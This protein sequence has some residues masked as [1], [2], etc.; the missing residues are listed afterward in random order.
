MLAFL[1]SAPLRAEDLTGRFAVGGAAG[2]GVPLGNAWVRDHADPAGLLLGGFLRYG[3]TKHLSLGLSYD[4]LGLGKDGIRLQPVLFNVYYNLKP[5]SCWNPN[6]HL[7]MGAA[8]VSRD[9]FSQHTNFSGKLG[10]GAD[11]F[12]L[13]N[14]AVGGFLD[15][16]LVVR[17]LADDYSVH[18]LLAGLTVALWFDPFR[19]HAAE[20]W[21][22]KAPAVVGVALTPTTA[23]L[24][25]N[26]SLPFSASVTGTQNAA[27]IWS[28]EPK[29]GTIT[30]SGTYQAPAVIT[31]EQTVNITATS[32]ADPSKS[33][34]SQVTLLAPA[35]SVV[36]VTLAPATAE[37]SA[38][39]SLPFS[40]SVSGTPNTA[41]TWSLQPRLGTITGSGAY[42][43]PAVIAAEQTVYVTATSQAD[44]SKSATSQLRLRAPAKVA[45]RLA[46]EF[47]IAQAVVKPQYD[48]ELQKV[49]QFIQ[50][51]PTARAEIEGHT[52]KVG[53][54]EYNLAL[55][56]RRAEA[57][58]EALI[59]RCGVPADRL[60]ARGYGSTQPIADN[61]TREGRARNRRVI[62]TFTGTKP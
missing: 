14:V 25:A 24:A 62:A 53:S 56:Q 48:Y 38:N 16:F 43:A 6:I 41:V 46:I 7:G 49:A 44:P 15:Y 1:L 30:G 11:Y 50:D 42:T 26:S 19:S 51:Y 52:D 45:M 40:A 32:Q 20:P 4:D 31:A 54:P 18:G 36:S 9:E 61:R 3:F 57:V 47:D 33:A 29:L 39:A 37:L 35:P 8:D 55:S 22:A 2:A 5:D 21:Q 23:T 12:L 34:T 60:T 10:L 59:S 17:Y 28:L 58:R 27:V 13:K